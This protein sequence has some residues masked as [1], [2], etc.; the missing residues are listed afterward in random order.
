MLLNYFVGKPAQDFHL[1][2]K[3]CT[4]VDEIRIEEKNGKVV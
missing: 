4:E 3:K 1:R 2:T